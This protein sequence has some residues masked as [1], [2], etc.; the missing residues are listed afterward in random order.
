MTG[1]LMARTPKR[2]P[3]DFLV[4]ILDDLAQLRSTEYSH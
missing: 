2:A 4:E 1:L 3:I